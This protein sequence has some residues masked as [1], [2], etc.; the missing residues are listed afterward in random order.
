MDP[1]VVISKGGYD[2]IKAVFDY[3][4][5]GRGWQTLLYSN[6]V[7]GIQKSLSLHFK[8][9]ITV[10]TPIIKPVPPSVLALPYYPQTV[11]G[12]WLWESLCH[13]FKEPNAS[14]YSFKQLTFQRH[15]GGS[16]IWHPAFS[17]VSKW[18]AVVNRQSSFDSA[19]MRSSPRWNAGKFKLTEQLIAKK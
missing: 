13:T 4:S 1:F 8:I 10:I 14:S 9:L 6:G 7:A 11:P 5:S 18:T 16:M 19:E 3:S 15:H 12:H 17:Q 2:E